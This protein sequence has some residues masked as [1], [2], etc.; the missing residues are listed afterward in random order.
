[1]RQFL[2]TLYW[3]ILLTIFTVWI[4]DYTRTVMK[5]PPI[6]AI[7][8]KVKNYD[9]GNITTYKGIGY[10]I[11]FYNRDSYTAGVRYMPI[12]KNN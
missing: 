9:D 8:K 1:M 5:E 4:T 2:N 10:K 6:F 7:S 3:V 12:Y 11:V